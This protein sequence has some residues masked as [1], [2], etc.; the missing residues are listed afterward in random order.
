MWSGNN[1]AK[2]WSAKTFNRNAVACAIL[3][4]LIAA[5]SDVEYPEGAFTAGLLKSVGMLL[6]AIALPDEHLRIRQIYTTQS[7]S[8]AESEI[9][10]LGF[11]HAAL[12]GDILKHWNLPIQIQIAVAAQTLTPN[13]ESLALGNL[14]S[15]AAAIVD[16]TGNFVQDWIRPSGST[17]EESLARFGYP[18]QVQIAFQTEFDAMSKFFS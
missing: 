2:G 4:D 6:I 18:P 5:E 17:A 1:P 9:E 14:L 12:S 15:K 16:S 8:L 7:K 13:L 11:S 10:V 3:A